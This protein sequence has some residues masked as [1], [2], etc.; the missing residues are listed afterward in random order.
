MTRAYV[1]EWVAQPW[2]SLAAHVL[3]KG[4]VSGAL[5]QAQDARGTSPD[6]AAEPSVDWGAP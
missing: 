6:D 1:V 4:R 5:Q 2:Q 3:F